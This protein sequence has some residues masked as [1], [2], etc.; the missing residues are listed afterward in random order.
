MDRTLQQHIDDNHNE[1]ENLSISSQRRQYIESELN[2]LNKYL[3]TH[4]D[5]EHDPT[6]FEM[7]CDENPDALQCRIYED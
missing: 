7:F 5:K 1:L 3:E 4:S 2:S 6:P